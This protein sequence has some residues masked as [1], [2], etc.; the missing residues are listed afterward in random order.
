MEENVWTKSSVNKLLSDQY[1]IASLYVDEQIEL[2]KNEQFASPFLD[3]KFAT[4][5]GDKWF[6][7]SLRHFKSATQPFYA[8]IDPVNNRILN[9]PRGFTPSESEYTKFLE[10]GLTNYKS[11]R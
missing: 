11:L 3:K 10:C 4:T 1:I 5:V 7:L 2:P 9:T 6:D 8:L